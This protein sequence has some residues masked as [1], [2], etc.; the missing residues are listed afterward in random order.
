M[1]GSGVIVLSHLE[2][3]QLVVLPVEGFP[4]R[5]SWW[6]LYPR[7]KRLS[8]IAQEFLRHLEA[9]AAELRGR[10]PVQT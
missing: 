1:G 7:G 6:I 10:F 3:D 2:D 4:V 9:S 5:C 8:P